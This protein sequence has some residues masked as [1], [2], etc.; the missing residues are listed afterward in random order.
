MRAIISNSHGPV[1]QE[2]S[3]P[4]YGS[5]GVLVRVR[6]GSLNRIDLALMKGMTHGG[7]G[8]SGFPL[9]VEW[10]GE[11]VEVGGSVT[12]W[13]VGDRVMAAGG[14]AFAEFAVGSE[15]Q[16]YAVPEGVSFEQAACLPVSMQTMH[17]ALST[18]GKLAQ[19]QTVLFQGASSGMGIMGMQAAKYLGA[20]MVIGSSTTQERRDR[21]KE[22]GADMVFDSRLPEWVSE[23]LEATNGRGVDLLIDFLA[24]PLVN[25]GLLATRIGGRMINIGRM[26]GES[27]EFNFDLHNMRRIK[28]IGASFRLRTPEEVAAVI[29]KASEALGPALKE[30][31]LRMPM[32]SVYPMEEAHKAFEKMAQNKHFGK[33]VISID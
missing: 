19:G 8:G 25:D 17:D 7:L 10:A 2:A 13:A 15:R 32:D 27:G 5:D 24:G 18:N 14:G 28:Y 33:I 20:G 29:E 22:F 21:L 6:A 26:A 30:G 9:G 16:M 1:L 12:R 31:A 3:K 4:V 23:V 11:V